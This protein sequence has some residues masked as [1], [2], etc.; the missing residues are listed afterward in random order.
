VAGEDGDLKS[1]TCGLVNASLH[2]TTPKSKN[3]TVKIGRE[4]GSVAKEGSRPANL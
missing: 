2:L 4:Y 1:I 3:A